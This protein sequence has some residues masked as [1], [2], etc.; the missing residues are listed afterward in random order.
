M[1]RQGNPFTP[2][3]DHGP[4]ALAHAVFCPSFHVG[5]ERN[6]RYGAFKAKVRSRP[7][8]PQVRGQGGSL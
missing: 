3:W 6:N 5:E 7:A 4:D 1:V 2:L 8:F